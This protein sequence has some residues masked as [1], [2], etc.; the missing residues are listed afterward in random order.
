M[1]SRTFIS[2]AGSQTSLEIG[3]KSLI[4]SMLGF[5]LIAD[6]NK[7]SRIFQRSHSTER[8]NNTKGRFFEAA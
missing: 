6:R 3:G 8:P 2:V 7:R 1:S 5:C 4:K